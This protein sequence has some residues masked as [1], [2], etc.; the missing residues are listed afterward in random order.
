MKTLY[1]TTRFV[2]K[3]SK[4]VL[5]LLLL[6][7]FSCK[8]KNNSDDPTPNTNTVAVETGQQK[9]H[10][11]D[12]SSL[13]NE[14]DEV[15]SSTDSVMSSM[16]TRF[17][18]GRFAAPEQIQGF[19]G[20]VIDSSTSPGSNGKSFTITFNG[21]ACNGKVKN[22]KIKVE[23]TQGNRWKDIGAVVTIT[24][25]DY[26]VRKS[27]DDSDRTWHINGT[28]VIKNVTGGLLRHLW[29]QTDGS[30]IIHSIRGNLQLK[31]DADNSTRTWQI[32]RKRTFT[33]NS[34]VSYSLKIEGDTSINGTS[35]IVTT[36]TNRYGNDFS[37]QISEPILLTNTCGWWRP[38]SGTKVH[39]GLKKTLT[40]T[41]G[42][43]ITG[44]RQTSGCPNY[45]K[46]NWTGSD[47]N[48]KLAVLKY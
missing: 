18:T 17:G 4:L 7:T 15:I 27:V 47:G 28:H 1:S 23:L 32:F 42:T 30:S 21:T 25:I 5:V 20:S 38:V 45:Y 48:S 31:F 2:N 11:A 9:V 37:V 14:S 26:S 36:G 19:C 10:A 22:G 39:S 3:G 24:F 41:F 40:V 34:L 33:K 13:Q 44:T 8:K 16:T 35:G 12:E 6:A 46:L 43:D 29:A